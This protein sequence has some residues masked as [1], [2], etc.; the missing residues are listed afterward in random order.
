MCGLVWFGWYLNYVIL[1][2]TTYANLHN[3]TN[4]LYKR[5]LKFKEM[6]NIKRGYLE[7][8]TLAIFEMLH[9]YSTKYVL[10]LTN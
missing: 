2:D 6:V 8:D 7:T 5:Y 9:S 3:V 4:V 1:L 10:V